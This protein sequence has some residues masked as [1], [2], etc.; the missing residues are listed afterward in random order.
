M[1]I[2]QVT[3][4]S[5]IPLMGHI[6]FGIIDRG[7]S[8]IQVR[9]TSLCNLSCTFC[10]TDAGPQSTTHKTGYVVDPDYL[11]EEVRKVVE[12]KGKTHINID[13]VGEPAS[14][15][16]LVK[17]VEAFH[18]MPNVYFISMQ[19]NG[20][21]F[22]NELIDALEIAGLNRI[23]LSVHTTNA[24]QA[25]ALMGDSSYDHNK[26]MKAAERINNSSIELLFAPVVL[27]GVN[28]GEVE[29]LIQ[30]AKQWKCK[31]GIQKYEGYKYSRKMKGVKRESYYQF[32]KRLKQWEE[33]YDIQLVYHAKDLEIQQS[34]ALEKTGD[35]GE[36]INTPIL[37]E[38]WFAGQKIAAHK[39]RAITV[40]NCDAQPG[41]RINLRVIENKNNIYLAEAC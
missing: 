4:D 35:I 9:P 41:D 17:I 13:S 3:K 37:S 15:P 12:K 20:T 26:T 24:E 11:I 33:K 16:P 25:K 6:A 30:V 38:G 31:I 18:A 8:L 5:K 19:S 23:H 39:Q 36:R 34:P 40:N 21:Y 29:K 28:E 14:Y 7:S 22:T 32:Y 2:V 27:P 1:H 10:S